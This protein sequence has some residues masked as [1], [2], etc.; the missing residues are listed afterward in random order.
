MERLTVSSRQNHSE[1]RIKALNVPE[2]INLVLF[3]LDRI[4]VKLTSKH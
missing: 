3:L 4:T 1:T 2:E